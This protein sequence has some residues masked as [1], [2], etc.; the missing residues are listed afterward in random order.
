MSS[1]KA[2][3]KKELDKKKYEKYQKELD[4]NARHEFKGCVAAARILFGSYSSG[5]IDSKTLSDAADNLIKVVRNNFGYAS[6]IDIEE[7]IRNSTSYQETLKKENSLAN[8][9]GN[10]KLLFID[11]EYK[12]V[13]WDIV[14]DAIC[15]SGKVL[16]SDTI[17][18][19]RSLIAE[20]APNFA[21]VLLDMKLPSTPEEGLVFLKELKKI[22]ID[23]PVIM[24]TAEDNSRLVKKCFQYGALDY[25]VKE[26]KDND[27]DS[28]AYYLKLKEILIDALSQEDWR[29]VWSKICALENNLKQQGPPFYN[30]A[31][32]YLKKA[33]FFLTTDSESWSATMLLSSYNLTP[34]GEVILQCALA[35]E[36]IIGKLYN[37]CKNERELKAAAVPRTFEEETLGQKIGKLNKIRVISDDMANRLTAVNKLRTK[38]VHSEKTKA[39][40]EEQARKTMIE[41]ISLLEEIIFTK[42][43][44]TP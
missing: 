39:F 30:E 4:G 11:D 1:T 33:Y 3:N 9:L 43:L 40:S 25:F 34:Y 24:F 2:E 36:M 13:G 18:K 8:S 23:L 29:T 10:R 28:L 15:G 14:L 22:Y 5:D 37:N 44:V 20:D 38:S 32:D 12:K 21:A 26:F 6:N 41:T 17:D 7:Y 16:Y 35:L 19:G 31:V 42:L 27:K